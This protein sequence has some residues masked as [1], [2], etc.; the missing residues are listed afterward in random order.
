MSSAKN[1]KET[2]ADEIEKYLSDLAQLNNVAV[3]F[4]SNGGL[5]SLTAQAKR[6]LYRIVREATGNA[7]P[8]RELRQH[9]SQ[10]CDV[11]LE[12]DDLLGKTG[13]RGTANEEVALVSWSGL[14]LSCSAIS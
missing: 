12:Y 7:D 13:M 5:G 4:S 6:H 1:D 2:L 11:I 3:E 8:A 9:Q 14:S 10:P